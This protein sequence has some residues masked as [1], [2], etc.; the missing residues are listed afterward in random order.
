M[1]YEAACEFFMVPREWTPK[2]PPPPIPQLR[3]LV[4]PGID[5][6]DALHDAVRRVYDITAD[7]AALRNDI[8]S[9]DKLRAEYSVRREFSNT[10]LVLR[11]ASEVLRGTFLGLGFRV[12]S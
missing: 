10:E 4:E 12:A 9:F 6:E 3:V 5:N 1:I 8:R 2:L 7:D 11:G